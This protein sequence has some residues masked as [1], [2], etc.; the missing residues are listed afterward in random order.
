MARKKQLSLEEVDALLASYHSQ[1]T[2]LDFQAR[3]IEDIIKDLEKDRAAAAKRNAGAP[4]KRSTTSAKPRATGSTGRRRGR[5]PGSKNKTSTASAARKVAKKKPAA[6]KAAKPKATKTAKPAAKKAAP[7]TRKSAASDK[8]GYRLSDWDQ[9]LLDM[10]TAANAPMRKS[11]LDA[12]FKGHKLA[13]AE[14]MN[15]EAVYTKVSRVLHKL[16]NKRG[17]VK[18]VPSEG[19]GFAY[20]LA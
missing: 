2:Q 15:E 13:K 6:S 3:Q 4:A 9:A 1:K 7:K 16:A 19:K 5:P 14:K 17:I 18:K 11:D 8:G 12:K 10:L 20:A